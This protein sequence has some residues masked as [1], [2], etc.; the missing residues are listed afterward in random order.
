MLLH[1]DKR[2]HHHVLGPN[3]NFDQGKIIIIGEIYPKTYRN[4]LMY[5]QK[6]YLIHKQ[7]Y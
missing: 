6:Y 7:S 5:S 2:L 3:K 4:A 1:D